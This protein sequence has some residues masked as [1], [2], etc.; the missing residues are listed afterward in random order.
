M[1]RSTMSYLFGYL[2]N[3]FEAGVS[4]V[5]TALQVSRLERGTDSPSFCQGIE[6][7]EIHVDSVS[8][9]IGTCEE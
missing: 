8:E 5:V 1:H 4:L 6:R 2:E 3:R 9:S 7:V